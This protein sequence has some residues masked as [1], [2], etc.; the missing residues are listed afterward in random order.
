MLELRWD[1]RPPLDTKLSR[2][3]ES[4]NPECDEPALIGGSGSL[5]VASP[6]ARVRGV[7]PLPGAG[8][9]SL[10]PGSTRRH[11]GASHCDREQQ[12]RDYSRR[13]AGHTEQRPERPPTVVHAG[14]AGD[15]GNQSTQALG[16]A[17]AR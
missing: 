12:R 14:G 2:S 8:A 4:K 5:S 1:G 7:P 13:I 15:S 9:R 10:T 3:V 16:C 11:L 6:T 17:L